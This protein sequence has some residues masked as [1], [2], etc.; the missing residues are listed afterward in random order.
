M[1][2]LKKVFALVT[3]GALSRILDTVDGKVSAETDRDRIKADIIKAHYASRTGYMEAGG[4][5]L[6]LLFAI[7]L[8]FWF[9]AV[10]VYSALWCEGC[11]FPQAWTVA[12][13]PSPLDEWAGLIILSIFGVAGISRLA[14]R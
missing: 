12:A 14:R 13:L 1:W 10:C 6:M 8:A 2:F 7:P 3:G 4:F 9:G 5:W 11:A